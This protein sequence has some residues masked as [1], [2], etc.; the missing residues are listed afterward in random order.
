MNGEKLESLNK[1]TLNALD[2]EWL[3][4]FTLPNVNITDQLSVAELNNLISIGST[5][6]N[7]NHDISSRNQIV[8]A[9]EKFLLYVGVPSSVVDSY[10]STSITLCPLDTFIATQ[11][12]LHDNNL[13]VSKINQKY[14]VILG[15]LP[16]Q[17]Q[18]KIEGLTTLGLDAAKI[19]NTNPLA[20]SFST[21]MVKS[22]LTNLSDLGLDSVRIFNCY[23]VLI[24][25][26]SQTVIN[27]YN[28]IISL[29]LDATKIINKYPFLL[30]FS[31]QS[32]INKCNN[33]TNL[34]LDTTKV[35]T[36]YP[37]LL[38]LSPELIKNKVKFLSDAGLDYV[39]I[40]NKSS[41][42][43]G[44]A[45]D[46]VSSKINNLNSLGF[47]AV[48]IINSNPSVL[49]FNIDTVNSKLLL[50]N[51][52][53][54]L[55]KWD[56]SAIDLINAYPIILGFSAN[57]LKI[58]RRIASTYIDYDQNYLEPKVIA[59]ALIRPLEQYLL[60]VNGLDDSKLS[61]NSLIKEVSKYKNYDSDER[62][63]YAN[64]LA[65]TG[66]LGRIGTMYLNYSS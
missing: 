50:L 48:K 49:S 20:M 52:T 46:N 42:I 17:I 34:G 22:K 33:F 47:D 19:I 55:L 21:E 24:G 66:K 1:P 29:G 16:T 32:V 14:T 35:L 44:L 27:K 58:L 13:D 54:K 60:A 62:K 4:D 7:V 31:E 25:S 36:K 10:K 57:K 53:A 38:S 11:Q 43:L 28:N 59:S 3:C 26:S 8:E 41:A 30:Y 5:R 40:I 45:T 51:R 39:K 65:N 23:P 15:C 56:Y 9:R 12:I 37:Y 18:S 2:Y 6:I 61:L 63:I 64:D